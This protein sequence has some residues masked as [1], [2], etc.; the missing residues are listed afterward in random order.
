[1]VGDQDFNAVAPSTE[2]N[3]ATKPPGT[4]ETDPVDAPT[5][6]HGRFY[7]VHNL[8]IHIIGCSNAT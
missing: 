3:E 1:M 6:K 4:G 2:P 8:A 5:K 7:D